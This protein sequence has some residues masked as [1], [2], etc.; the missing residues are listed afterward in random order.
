M[1]AL[2]SF[3]KR[4]AGSKKIRNPSTLISIVTDIA[5][6]NPRTYSSTAAILSVLIASL[7]KEK[8]IDVINKIVQKFDLLPNTGHIELWL[9]R[10][11]IHFD[12]EKP[13]DETLCKRVL[14]HNVTVWNSEWL[15]PNCKL[16]DIISETKF[17]NHELIDEIDPIIDQ[18]EF[19]LFVVPYK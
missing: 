7:G 2:S 15:D 6:K 4:I 5:F 9:Q 11:T 17:V 14:D 3:Y 8:R 16:R 10:I 1:R 13:Y 19:D 18:N 12:K